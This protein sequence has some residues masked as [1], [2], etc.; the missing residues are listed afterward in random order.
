MEYFL[1]VLN[2]LLTTAF[3]TSVASSYYLYRVRGGKV[4]IALSLLFCLYFVDNF[5]VFMTEVIPSFEHIYDIVFSTSPFFKAFIHIGLVACYAFIHKQILRESFRLSTMY[6]WFF[7]L[8]FSSLLGLFP[9]K[10]LAPGHFS[11]QRS[12]LTAVLLFT[13]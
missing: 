13:A 3:A 9:T 11:C 8:W 12:C 5:L 10:Q 7:T 4:F 6:C 2:I 1:F